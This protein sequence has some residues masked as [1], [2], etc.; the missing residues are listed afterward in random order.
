MREDRPNIVLI[1]ADSVRADHCGYLNDRM[2]TT[3]TIDQIADRG[4]AFNEAFSPGPRTPSSIPE[5]MTD[6]ELPDDRIQTT[7]WESRLARVR[8]HISKSNPLAARLQDTGYTTIAFTSNPHTDEYTGFDV[9]FD[10]FVQVGRTDGIDLNLLEGT[11]LEPATKYIDQWWNGAGFFSRWEDFFPDIVETVNQ[12]PDPYFLWVFLLDS[13]NPYRAPRKDREESTLWSMYL[14]QLRANSLFL[15]SEVTAT[16]SFAEGVP[17]T[18]LAGIKRAYRD[19]IRSVD[20]CVRELLQALRDDDPLVV[21]HS[22]HGEAFGEHG[23]FGHQ[24]RLYDE[25]LH[26]PLVV[27]NAGETDEIDGQVSLRHL[28]QMIYSYACENVPFTRSHWQ[29]SETLLRT[30]DNSRYGIRTENW[31][32]VRTDESEELFDLTQDPGEHADVANSNPDR[33]ARFR[34]QLEG[35]IQDLPPPGEY[36]SRLS[37]SRSTVE[38]RLSDLG[39]LE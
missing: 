34:R 5:I 30:E 27:H 21:F 17:E 37:E 18:I 32:Y 20:R 3:P 33:T 26:V 10:E 22:D 2:E 23:T 15:D 28:D 36:S 19:S 31:K 16:S 7:D 39:Y 13:H 6:R 12:A 38:A 29:P 35:C 9:G 8:D 11:K 14:S 4:I 1:T 24:R 25:N